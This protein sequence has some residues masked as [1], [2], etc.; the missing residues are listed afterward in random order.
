[1]SSFVHISSSFYDYGYHDYVHLFIWWLCLYF[2][3][4][5]STSLTFSFT[6]STSF[7]DRQ[8]IQAVWRFLVRSRRFRRISCSVLQHDRIHQTIIRGSYVNYACAGKEREPKSFFVP[9]QFYIN[10]IG[11]FL[12]SFIQPCFH[13]YT[14]YTVS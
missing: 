8:F 6:Y 7:L 11:F 2:L 13:I 1:M 4:C 14:L 9:F 10:I 12:H 5:L 3:D